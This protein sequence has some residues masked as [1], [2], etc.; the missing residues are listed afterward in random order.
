MS[1]SRLATDSGTNIERPMT[2]ESS[3]RLQSSRSRVEKKT[4]TN[5]MAPYSESEEDSFFED[6]EEEDVSISEDKWMSRDDKEKEVLNSK[7]KLSK[8]LEQLQ[9][10]LGDNIFSLHYHETPFLKNFSYHK[11]WRN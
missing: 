1:A 6:D 5:K 10:R 3:R 4:Y 7:P 9:R 8:H 2:A 11:V